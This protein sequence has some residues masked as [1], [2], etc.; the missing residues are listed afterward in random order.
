MV[1]AVIKNVRLLLTGDECPWW[2][3]LK[4]DD[5]TGVRRHITVTTT[6]TMDAMLSYKLAWVS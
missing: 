6:T 1:I 3:Y 2:A 4:Y 5:R